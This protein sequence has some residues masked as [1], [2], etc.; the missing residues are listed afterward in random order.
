VGGGGGVVCLCV[1]CLLGIGRADAAGAH[2]HQVICALDPAHGLTHENIMVPMARSI[3]LP[4]C[5]VLSAGIF[6]CVAPAAL[7]KI[8]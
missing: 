3:R 7:R 8:D 2:G 5:P 1:A 4:P 6:S